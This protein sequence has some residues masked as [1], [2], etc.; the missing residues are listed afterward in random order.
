MITAEQLAAATGAPYTKAIG[1]VD[2]V[3]ATMD[4]HEINTP[5]RQ[6]AF[7]A[8]IG[9]ESCGL[10]FTRELWGPTDDQKGYEGRKDLGNTQDGDGK[11]FRG[12]GLIQITGRAN[13]RE[14]GV[15]LG[16]DCVTHPELLE[17]PLYAAE[18]SGLYWAK[19]RLNAKA[20]FGDFKGI[21]KVINGGMN[22]YM[23]RVSRWNKAKLALGVV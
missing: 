10:Q 9:H 15:A 20:D 3:N 16:I 6:A 21:T 5:A 4:K 8:Q 11:R 23:D 13:Y 22:G 1:W 19:N 17:V 12:R 14:M 2:S 18:V 7:L